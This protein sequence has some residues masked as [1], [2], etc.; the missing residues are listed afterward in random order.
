[1]ELEKLVATNASL[2]IL[3]AT[4]EAYPLIKTGGLADVS[5][6]LPAALRELG[7]DCRILMPAYTSLLEQTNAHPLGKPWLPLAASPPVELYLGT[8]PGTGVPVYLAS[9]SQLY[10]RGGGPY[11][12]AAGNEWEDNALR[13]GVLSKVGADMAATAEIAGWSPDLVHCNDWQTGILPAYLA[14]RP[15]G[16]PPVVAGIHNL[17]FQG[18]FPVHMVP[19][20]ELPW[21]SF[22]QHGIEFFGSLSFMKAALFYADWITTVSPTY[23]DEIC[24]S[25]YGA[26]M[27]GLLSH[28]RGHLTGILNGIDRNAWDP[29]SDVYIDTNYDTESLDQ[30]SSN[31]KSLRASLRLDTATESILVG[32]VSRMAWQKGSDLVLDIAERMWDEPIQFAILGSGDAELERRWRRLA[33][34]NPGNVAVRNDYDEKLAHQIEAGADLFLMPSRFE[35]CGLNQIYSLRY[36]TPPIVRRT[37]GLADTVTDTTP[38]TLSAGTATGFVF[39]SADAEGLQACLLRA[40]L[41]HR[42]R[43][44]WEQIQK[45]AMAQ[46]FGWQTSAE[47]YLEIY[48]RLVRSQY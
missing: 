19:K 6:A 7:V 43:D 28:R 32:M 13:F 9:C 1:V 29:A 10:E 45:Q 8:L 17:I 20:L 47:K 38:A 34:E 18:N 44:T 11:A 3:F 33:R 26:G 39:G 16:M 2:A 22:Q 35:P 40:M 42:D 5:C 30:K 31:T 4:S 37:G 23:A 24:T 14:L 21:A 25:E 46:D 27:E 48:R 41:V 36:G 15:G 12:D